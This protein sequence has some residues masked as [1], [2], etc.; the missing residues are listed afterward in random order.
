MSMHERIYEGTLAWPLMMSHAGITCR[1]PA[2]ETLPP[3]GLSEE[4]PE[5]PDNMCGGLIIGQDY[6]T[7]DDIK[8]AIEEHMRHG[9][10]EQV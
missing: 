10:G 7:L 9:H 8:D 2:N 1:A 4:D 5:V 3:W 6:L